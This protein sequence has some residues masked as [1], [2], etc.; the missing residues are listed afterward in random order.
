M[1]KTKS[2]RSNSRVR[3]LITIS[4]LTAIVLAASTYAW[5][6][7][8][9]TVNVSSFD[10]EIAATDSLLLSLNGK[11]FSE[12]VAIS[13]ALLTEGDP[14]VTYAGHSNSWG[15]TGLIPMSSIGE[16]DFAASRLVT[17]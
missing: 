11:D 2:W 12:T 17:I 4:S 3:N 15:G 9:R 16:M 10:V 8:M 14:S 7:G 6:V 5:F 1:P 13:Q